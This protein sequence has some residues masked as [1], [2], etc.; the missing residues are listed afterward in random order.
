LAYTLGQ[1]RGYAQA[2]R[3]IERER[4]KQQA[5]AAR[6]AQADRRGWKQWLDSL[7]DKNG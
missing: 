2:V 1:L 3:R 4:V 5:V 7:E 6:V